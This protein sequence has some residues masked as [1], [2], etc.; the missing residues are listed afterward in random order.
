MSTTRPVLAICIRPLAQIRAPAGSFN[1]HSLDTIGRNPRFAGGL[2][3][4]LGEDDQQLAPQAE[5][6]FVA[7]AHGIF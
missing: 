5:I 7:E 1:S 2:G 6:R 4:D 3:N